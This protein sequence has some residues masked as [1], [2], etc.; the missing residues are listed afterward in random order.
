MMTMIWAV[1][2]VL[3][4]QGVLAGTFYAG[5]R[6]GRKRRAALPPVE[7]DSESIRLE[8]LQKAFRSIMS[9]DLNTAMKGRSS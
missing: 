5:Y 1:L 8:K 3:A 9:Y 7:D 6:F 4:A 2:A